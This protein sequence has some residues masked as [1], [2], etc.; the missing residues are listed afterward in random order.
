MKIQPFASAILLLAICVSAVHAQ[1]GT[2]PNRSRTS[3][4]VTM[5]AEQEAD[6]LVSLSANK[7]I[8]ISQDEPGLLLAVKRALVHKAYE[9]GR[10]LDPKELTDE[11]VFRLIREDDNI[12]VLASREVEDRYYVRAKPNREEREQAAAML[13]RE[14]QRANVPPD[15]AQQLREKQNQ[16]DSYWSWTKVTIES[17]TVPGYLA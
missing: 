4:D 17:R 15:Q 5:G 6:R 2:D 7:I 8:E 9:Q 10:I 16:E 13:S 1:N 14:P 12:R 11:A 3:S